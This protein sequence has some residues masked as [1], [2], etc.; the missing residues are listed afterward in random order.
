MD[1]RTAGNEIKTDL[2]QLIL[3]G[4]PNVGKSSIFGALTGKYVTVSNYPGTTV[5]VS[6]GNVT[7][8]KRKYLVIDT[9]GAN[10]LVPMSEDEQVTRDILIEAD[11]ATVV[12]V[13]DSKNLRRGLVVSTQL[14]EFEMPFILVLNMADEARSRGIRINTSGLQKALGV[15]VVSTTATQ[16]QGIDRLMSGISQ[17]VLSSHRIKF[18]RLIEESTSEIEAL[19]TGIEKGK[20]GIALTV[21]S[22]DD[23]F[24]PWLHDHL[25]EQT[26]KEIEAIRSRTQEKY[27]QPLGYVINLRRLRAVDRLVR[28]LQTT[29]KTLLR[30]ARKRSRLRRVHP[31]ISLPIFAAALYGLSMLTAMN[32]LFALLSI[33]L[34]LFSLYMFGDWGT[35]QVYGI[36]ILIGVLYL[37]WLFVGDFGAGAAVNFLQDTVFGK[38]INPGASWLIARVLPWNIAKELLIGQ[39]GIITMAMTYAIAIVLPIVGTFF[40]AFGMLEDSGYLPRLAVMVDKIFK[41]MGLNGKAVLPMVLGLG[42]GTMATLTARI[43]DTKRERVIVTLLLALGVPCSAQLGVIL[44]IFG[45]TGAPFAAMAIWMGVVFGVIFLVG[46]LAGKLMPGEKTDFI[47]EVPPTR[48]PQ[49][50]NIAIKTFARMTWYLKE[51][52]PLFIIGTLVLFFSDKLKLLSLIEKAAAPAV[53]GLLGLPAKATEA[54]IISFLRRDYGVAGLYQMSKAGQLDTVQII[55]GIVTITLFVPCLPNFLVIIKERGIKTAIAI[56]LFIIPFSFL[57]GGALNWILRGLRIFS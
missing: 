44:G 13:A 23:S 53:Q 41:A 40:I 54:F 3:V 33:P 55:V 16:R 36:P 15:H 19:L 7:L 38:Y 43:L 51:A 37:T 25:P 31:L 39:Y 22:G 12:Q 26:I 10:S 8:N 34:L 14:A 17:A 27:T 5:E 1:C 57:V 24:T 21:L 48:L 50:T 35:H 47:M 20:R 46:Y 30:R 11:K 45:S 9:P 49:I 4:N 42:C 18:D 6:Q 28:S 56:I 29:E 52:V 2:P 32:P